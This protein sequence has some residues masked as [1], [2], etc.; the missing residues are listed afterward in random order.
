[1]VAAPYCY[2]PTSKLL[3]VAEQL[4]IG[5]D[6]MYFGA[7]PGLALARD[8]NF[9]ACVELKDR[10]SWDFDSR[11]LLATADVAI[12]F[13]EYRAI[14]VAVGQ[15]V[16]TF[17]VDTLAWLRPSAPKYVEQANGYFSQRFLPS[18]PRPKWY[19]QTV[20]EV[21]PILPDVV[22]K[23][24]AHD[25]SS[26]RSAVRRSLR[27][28]G[29]V[30]INFGGL[31]S[32]AMIDGADVRYVHHALTLARE[33]VDRQTGLV[34]CLP[35]YLKGVEG[36][37]VPPNATVQWP[38]QA[39]FHE[40]MGRCATLATVPGLEVVLEA[41]SLRCPLIFLPPYNGTQLFQGDV[42]FANRIGEGNLR[43][44]LHLS[45]LNTTRPDDLNSVTAAVQRWVLD[46]D[47]KEWHA[48]Y[49]E[50]NRAIGVLRDDPGVAQERC[51]QNAI[52]VQS[53]G[54]AGATR[55]AKRIAAAGDP[56]HA[57]EDC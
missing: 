11:A 5:A 23:T 1:M 47:P 4:P 12:S 53:L 26:G 39:E 57:G 54:R 6:V 9:S 38:S 20:E 48:M 55:V 28:D 22:E 45:I 8:R 21:P 46:S 7:E 29:F 52:L 30:L 17:F 18:G 14:P 50:F 19:N 13:L 43:S 33:A 16:P 51:S 49:P 25:Q 10:D 56:H 27:S 40:L 44:P 3:C 34:I 42:Y 41:I 24:M 36:L 15:G 31:R 32:P 35:R 37:E 2:G